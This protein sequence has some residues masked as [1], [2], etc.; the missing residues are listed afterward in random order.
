MICFTI[1]P[2]CFYNTHK[3]QNTTIKYQ[4]A[5]YKYNGKKDSIYVLHTENKFAKPQVEASQSRTAVASCSQFFLIAK[6][7]NNVFYKKYIE[8]SQFF[9]SFMCIRDS[10]RSL[11]KKICEE[12]F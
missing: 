7:N 11:R 5:E 9:R 4:G 6:I 8:I 3:H 10:K 1:S 12:R 2:T